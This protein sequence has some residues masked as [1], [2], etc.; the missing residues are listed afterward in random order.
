MD[1]KEKRYHAFRRGTFVANGF[2][3]TIAVESDL[4]DTHIMRNLGGVCFRVRLAESGK[5]ATE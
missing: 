2:Y 1:T 5:E 3:G 4:I